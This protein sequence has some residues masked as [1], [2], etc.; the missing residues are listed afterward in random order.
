[1]NIVADENIPFVHELFGLFGNVT[2]IAGRVIN[3]DHL[4]DADILLV[5][6]V[7]QVNSQLLQHSNVKFVGTCTIGTDH[8]DKNYMRQHGITY[9]SAPGCNANSVVQYVLATLA[10]CG[11][12]QNTK[13][14]GIVG[15]GNVGSRLHSALK[16]LGFSCA[17]Y[18]PFLSAQSNADLCEWQLLYDC[19]ILCLHAPLT[20]H[21]DFPSFHMFSEKELNNLKP[22]C[23]F[24]NA[25]RGA[26]VS[27]RALLHCLHSRPNMM[28][29]LDV[30]E[31]EPNINL[32]LFKKV[33]LATPHIAGYSH[34]GR[35]NGAL[36]IFRSL[37]KFLK[38]DEMAVA[39]VYDDVIDMAFGQAASLVGGDV[40]Q[41][42][43]N[44]Y[45]PSED[46]Q[47][48]KD[49]LG[50]MPAAFDQLRKNYPKRREF[51]HYSISNT[52]DA[53]EAALLK[54]LGFM[55]N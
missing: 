47:R 32:D 7:T 6:S 33:L 45:R 26:V 49:G 24:L 13:T 18:D 22:D 27:N 9:T 40:N 54:S 15:C 19:D 39:R 41:L 42:I 29:V 46:F 30:W 23:L 34:E 5:R 44:T 51:S 28:A 3:S 48:M 11:V 16:T 1:M 14:V 43:L 17:V 25:G 31:N 35:T 37:A 21:G 12:L 52:Q 38:I 2:A 36:M 8:L 20:R 55:V 10:E 50:S 53:S 4:V